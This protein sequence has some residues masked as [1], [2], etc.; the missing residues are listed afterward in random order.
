MRIESLKSIEGVRFG[1]LENETETLIAEAKQSDHPTWITISWRGRV[2]TDGLFEF[3][4]AAAN[5]L[6]R[7]KLSPPS[8]DKLYG[9]V[10]FGPKV[11]QEFKVGTNK[12]NELR[13]R[14][15]E[16]ADFVRLDYLD[17]RGLQSETSED[18][19]EPDISVWSRLDKGELENQESC[20]IGVW[21]A[22]HALQIISRTLVEFVANTHVDH[23][24][25]TTAEIGMKQ[26][27]GSFKLG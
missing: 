18:E 17:F 19:F 6:N 4:D 20:R 9:I 26:L 22:P 13:R 1:A 23:I 12:L 15:P 8:D 21:A 3:F 5:L 7:N 27:F 25:S 10:I 16:G 14:V 2:D 11:S 24:T